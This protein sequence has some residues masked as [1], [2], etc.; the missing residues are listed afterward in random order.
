MIF[1]IDIE[2]KKGWSMSEKV[3]EVIRMTVMQMLDSSMSA[4]IFAE[5]PKNT[6]EK[7]ILF[8]SVT[9]L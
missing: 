8:P 2:L 9:E 4:K 3:K 5:W 7:Y 1:A 6:R